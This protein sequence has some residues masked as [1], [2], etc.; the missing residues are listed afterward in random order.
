MCPSAWLAVVLE[1]ALLGALLGALPGACLG[2]ARAAWDMAA[3]VRAGRGVRAAGDAGL[4]VR[5]MKH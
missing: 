1:A 2:D 4:E 3:R 5:R